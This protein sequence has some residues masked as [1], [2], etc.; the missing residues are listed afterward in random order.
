MQF[1]FSY[2]IRQL[3]SFAVVG[4]AI[5]LVRPQ[6]SV[7]QSSSSLNPCPRIYYEAP[8]NRRVLSP[9]GCPPN[10]ARQLREP[11]SVMTETKIPSLSDRPIQPPLPEGRR[12]AIAKV[13][14]KAQQVSVKLTNQLS[15]PVTYQ[16]VGETSPRTLE[17][18]KSVKLLNLPL[19]TTIT[20]VRKDG[21][22]MAIKARSAEVGMLEVML[23]VETT[24]GDTQGV[25]RI[26][27]D[28]QVLAN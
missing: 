25:V 6:Q 2:R 26:Q 18:G 24:L 14:P 1:T 17:G 15:S 20:T 12:A 13:Q 9:Q 5:G 16:V 4:L 28:G 27:Q 11:S 19:P 7:A 22:L 21:G 3:M 23:N 8:F 10:K